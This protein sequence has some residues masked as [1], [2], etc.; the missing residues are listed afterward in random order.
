MWEPKEC[1]CLKIKTGSLLL[2]GFLLITSVIFIVMDATMLADGSVLQIVPNHCADSEDPADCYDFYFKWARGTVAFGLAIGVIQALVSSLLL[3]GILMEKTRLFI[4]F[5]LVLL[6]Q[7]FIHIIFALDLL[8]MA[9]TLQYWTEMI[10][11]G[12]IFTLVIF[13]EVFFLL[14]VRAHYLQV[15]R[16]KMIMFGDAEV[17]K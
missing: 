5:M 12:V 6:T 10:T 3:Y 13:L 17:R 11:Y 4:P 16:S 1:C 9:G 8:Y 2:G 15:R 14:V 7:I